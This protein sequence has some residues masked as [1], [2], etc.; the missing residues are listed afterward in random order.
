MNEPRV[1]IIVRTKDRPR[2]L[3]RALRSISS[4]TLTE[5]E[6]VIINDGGDPA[7]VDAMVA[8]V[9]EAF[10]EQVRVLHRQESHGRWA[11]ANAGVTMTTA[12]YLV[13]H[14]DDDSW[15]PSFLAEAVRYLDSE[16]NAAR[17]GVVSKIEIVWEKVE[18]GDYVELGREIFQPHLAAPTLG[19]TML[20]NRFVPI[21]FVY[22]RT[23]HDELGL[24]DERLP[25]V[26]DWSF[27]M[28]VLTKGPLEYLDA[29]KPY[30]YWH[31]RPS[32]AGSDGNSVIS[33]STDHAA[34]DAQLR[35]EALR[36]WVAENGPGLP[37]YLTK[38]IDQ[39]LVDVEARIRDDIAR[40]S[41]PE[42]ALRVLKA[43]FGK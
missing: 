1:A 18:G 5:W 3:D 38:F 14:D 43:K 36:A 19:D 21:G 39:R 30:A 27:T 12:P 37:L 31:Q 32:S 23:L 11:S 9:P 16:K 25:V 42:R 7:G 35:D 8:R 4:Q 40:Y 22:R 20:H 17:G 41:L 24:Y 10:R 33:S 29:K 26:G 34:V 28:K 15:H 2:F 13:L 6:C